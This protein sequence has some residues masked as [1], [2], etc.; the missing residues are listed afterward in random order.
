MG[1]KTL[2]RRW[3][4]IGAMAFIVTPVGAG[5]GPA[6]EEVPSSQR[7]VGG[8]TD[9]EVAAVVQAINETEIELGRVALERVDMEVVRRFAQR[10]VDQHTRAQAELG[11]LLNELTIQPVEHDLVGQVRSEALR[12]RSRLDITPRGGLFDR[13]Y[14]DGQLQLL[15]SYLRL[16]NNRLVESATIPE[17]RQALERLQDDINDRLNEA[18]LIR[19]SGA[20]PH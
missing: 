2:I 8:L 14:I 15:N 11:Q 3:Y 7:Q 18:L 13:I 6:E 5:C 1:S 17:Y 16:L 12:E 9:A 20:V 19:D 10:V 4:L